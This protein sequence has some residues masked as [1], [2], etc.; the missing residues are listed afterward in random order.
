VHLW[1]EREARSSPRTSPATSSSSSG[2][3]TEPLNRQWFAQF[4][5]RLFAFTGL[6]KTYA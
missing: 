1:R 6:P 4:R 2:V 3:A 5:P